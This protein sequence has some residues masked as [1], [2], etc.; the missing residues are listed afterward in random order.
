MSSISFDRVAHAYDGTRGYPS[1]V[2]QQIAEG[3][4]RTARAM[5]QSVFLEIGVGTGRI[6]IPLA[7][8]GHDY[9]GVDIS[10][11]MLVQLEGKLLQRNWIEQQEPW[12]SRADELALS[13][14]PVR[15]FTRTDP[16]ASLRLV[17]SDITALPTYSNKF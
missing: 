6:A 17:T 1:G 4:E 15:R 12:G 11:K 3:L 16:S 13:A 2:E 10:E 14:R 5:E 8:R 7:S 9:T